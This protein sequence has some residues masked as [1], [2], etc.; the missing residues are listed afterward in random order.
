MSTGSPDL[1]DS[2]VETLS[3]CDYRL[4]QDDVTSQHNQY[5]ALQVL[6]DSNSNGG[7]GN[8]GLVAFGGRH[9]PPGDVVLPAVTLEEVVSERAAKAPSAA[10]EQLMLAYLGPGVL[11]L[12][13]AVTL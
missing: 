7:L 8:E 13:N 5:G 3:S 4:W 11:Y 2:S 9:C 1:G 12:P 6:G 10:R